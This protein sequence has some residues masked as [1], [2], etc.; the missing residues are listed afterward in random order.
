M[1]HLRL[2]MTGLLQ[3]VV[4][5]HRM[6]RLRRP[7]HRERFSLQASQFPRSSASEGMTH[8]SMNCGSVLKWRIREPLLPTE[9][10]LRSGR[11]APLHV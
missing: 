3:L 1:L 8:S 6:L 4:L 5:W 11:I 2:W 10:L 9:V 7:L